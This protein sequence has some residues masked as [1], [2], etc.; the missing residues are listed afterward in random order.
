M[1]DSLVSGDIGHSRKRVRLR[2]Y[3]RIEPHC[4]HFIGVVDV[5]IG[6]RKR[7]RRTACIGVGNR[8]NRIDW[9]HSWHKPSPGNDIRC[10][11][12]A[13]KVKSRFTFDDFSRCNRQRCKVCV[14][15]FNLDAQ[16]RAEHVKRDWEC[17]HKPSR[18]VSGAG[19]QKEE[20]GCVQRVDRCEGFGLH[21]F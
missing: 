10:V 2:K 5:V 12:S 11:R 8:S 20:S 13:R 15:G 1:R 6:G 17:C 9:L 19:G 18:T 7:L 3:D 14:V 16:A 4:E 21:D